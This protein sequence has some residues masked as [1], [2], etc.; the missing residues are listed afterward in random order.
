M[1]TVRV[2]D[3]N[4]MYQP[5]NSEIHK[6]PQR[7]LHAAEITLC[8]AT[9]WERTGRT[10]LFIK[11]KKY[12]DIF[13]PELLKIQRY[14]SLHPPII[15]TATHPPRPC[16]KRA[17]H[18][19]QGVGGEGSSSPS[20]QLGLPSSRRGCQVNRGLRPAPLGHL[21]ALHR[22]PEGGKFGGSWPRPPA[23]TQQQQQ[24]RAA[25]TASPRLTYLPTGR[26]RRLFG[27][28]KKGA[29]ARISES[30]GLCRSAPGSASSRVGGR[31]GRGRTLRWRGA[32][33]GGRSAQARAPGDRR[34]VLLDA[35]AAGTPQAFPQARCLANPA[36]AP[37]VRTS[38]TTGCRAWP[39]AGSSGWRDAVQTPT[40]SS[41][42]PAPRSAPLRCGGG[43]GARRLSSAVRAAAAASSLLRRPP[44][45]RSGS[46]ATPWR[47]QPP[48]TRRSPSPSPAAPPRRGAR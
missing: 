20:P 21:R 35:V 40:S 38:A 11:P 46:R 45:W 7:L 8:V 3:I 32:G 17:P 41:A 34:P 9:Y 10:H 1:L 15:H 39:E 4:F 5:A 13:P 16:P 33:A 31:R 36:D 2:G 43:R 37:A 6:N 47:L 48:L 19:A 29:G 42:R 28:G 25:A 18:G 22:A 24:Q 27:S 44:S 30:G 12:G 26:G 14:F 23:P